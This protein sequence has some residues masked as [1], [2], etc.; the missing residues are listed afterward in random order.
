[1]KR[2]EIRV[3]TVH[4]DG[5]DRAIAYYAMQLGS[6]S[7]EALETS[8][9]DYTKNRTAFP[10]VHL[11]YLGV[12]AD[13]QSQGVGSLMM[14]DVFDRVYAISQHVGFY[15]ITLQS[16]NASSTIFYERLGFRK[17]AGSDDSPKMLLPLRTVIELVNQNSKTKP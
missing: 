3:F 9:D 16:I 2:A 4:K 12:Q 7:T 5:T 15:A 8:P 17:Y 6:E 10:A 11:A 14:A 13:I 1:M